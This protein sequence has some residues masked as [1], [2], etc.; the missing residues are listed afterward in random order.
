MKPL[1]RAYADMRED[2]GFFLKRERIEAAPGGAASAALSGLL[3]G[4]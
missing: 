1:P 3:Q 4:E 2:S